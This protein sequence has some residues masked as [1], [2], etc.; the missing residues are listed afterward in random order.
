[1]S[2]KFKETKQKPY[3]FRQYEVSH[4]V[5]IGLPFLV[6]KKPKRIFQLNPF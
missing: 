2:M 3:R 5:S 1:M 4:T 6:K